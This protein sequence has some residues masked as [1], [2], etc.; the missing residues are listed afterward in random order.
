MGRQVNLNS[1]MLYRQESQDDKMS[2]DS[3]HTPSPFKKAPE[4]RPATPIKSPARRKSIRKKHWSS[5]GLKLKQKLS[6]DF[7][8]RMQEQLDKRATVLQ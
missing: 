3:A 2:I 5:A 6:E 8:T 1:D 7:A 4:V